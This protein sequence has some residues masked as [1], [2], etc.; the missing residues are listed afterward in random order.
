MNLL[1]L[2]ALLLT[3]GGW[4]MTVMTGTN[5]LSGHLDDR[6]CQ[7]DCVQTLFYSAVALGATGLLFTLAALLRSK[8]RMLSIFTLL[9]A[10]PLC[11]IFA[12][13]YIVGNYA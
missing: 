7:T 3:L 6:T 5:L 1:A 12:T 4:A 11:G 13:L 2:I 9:L 8:G 10:L